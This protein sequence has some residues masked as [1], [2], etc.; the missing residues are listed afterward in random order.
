VRARFGTRLRQVVLFGSRARGSGRA[1]SYL[2]VLVLVDGL[3]RAERREV[4]DE[5][6][7]VGGA[8]QGGRVR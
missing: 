7:R 2:D 3:T 5:G 8:L 4:L 1:D 6:A